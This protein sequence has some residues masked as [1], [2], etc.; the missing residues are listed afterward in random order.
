MEY[1]LRNKV[2]TD[3]SKYYYWTARMGLMTYESEDAW[4]SEDAAV[5]ALLAGIKMEESFD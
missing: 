1:T 2:L 3:G 4:W 5:S